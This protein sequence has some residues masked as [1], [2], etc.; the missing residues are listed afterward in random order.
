[1]TQI[2]TGLRDHRDDDELDWC[3]FVVNNKRAAI[4]N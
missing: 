4:S 2:K 1:M 3:C